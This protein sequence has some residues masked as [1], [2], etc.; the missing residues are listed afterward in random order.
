MNRNIWSCSLVSAALLLATVA[1]RG[2]EP[3]PPPPGFGHHGEGPE[4]GGPGGPFGERIELMG[5]EGLHPGK[6]VKGAPFSATASS[7]TTQTLQDG[8]TIHRNTS[9]TLY[10]DSQ[11]RSRREVTFSGFGPLQAAGKPHT[12]IAIN[13]PVAGAHYMLNPDQKVAHKMTPHKGGHGGGMSEDKAQAFEQRMQ[14]RIAKEE[15]SGE[16]K[17]ESLG[18]QAVNGVNAEGTRITRTIPAGQIGN[19]KPIQIVLERW[20]SPDL[21]IVVKSTRTDPRFGTTT[22]ALSNV[23]RAEPAAALF[24]VPSDYTVKEGGPGGRNHLRG[25]HGPPP[26]GESADVPPPA[27]GFDL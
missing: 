6:V 21:Q 1:S 16:I 23:Q 10:R 18:T 15:A 11:G 12:M 25:L 20:Y 26:A 14:Q 13:D 9:S 17:K 3:P 4:S 8:T 24:T 22:Y 7:D 2:Q 5:F 19:D 27:P